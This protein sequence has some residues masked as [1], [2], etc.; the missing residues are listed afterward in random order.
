M[1]GC[2]DPLSRPLALFDA[3]VAGG[4]ESLR[5]GAQQIQVDCA[6]QEPLLLVGLPGRKITVDELTKAGLSKDAADTLATSSLQRS[7][8]CSVEEFEYIPPAP[9]DKRKEIP[10]A[11]TNCVTTDLEI[12]QVV[13]TRATKMRVTLGKST[14]GLLTLDKLE[15]L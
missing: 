10:I 7:R 6:V 8:W 2:R 4:I 13:Q 9:N 12:K 1:V 5:Q 14:S 11:T 15:P 3:C